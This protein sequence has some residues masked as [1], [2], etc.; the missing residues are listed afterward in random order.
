MR[1]GAGLQLAQVGHVAIRQE[2][3]AEVGWVRG[4]LVSGSHT[5]LTC[6]SQALGSA[7]CSTRLAQPDQTPPGSLPLSGPVLSFLICTMGFWK[8]VTA[9]NI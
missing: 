7:G 4:W 2:L 8:E 5:A 3:R 6:P 1:V 9:A